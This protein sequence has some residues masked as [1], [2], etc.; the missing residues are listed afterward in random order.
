[1]LASS[2]GEIEYLFLFDL[3]SYLVR[4]LGRVHARDEGEVLVAE[5]VQQQ[6]Q[7]VGRGR[8]ARDVQLRVHARHRLQRHAQRRQALL[9]AAR[10]GRRHL[11]TPTI[12][13][14]HSH[15]DDFLYID[16]NFENLRANR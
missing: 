7:A 9:H 6:L 12:S 8:R 3:L 16:D 14:T 2:S 11:H 10:R 1:M 4:V 5:H 13:Y 15:T